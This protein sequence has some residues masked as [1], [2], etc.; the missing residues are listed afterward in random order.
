MRKVFFLALAA[1]V[2]ALLP[3]CTK[4]EEA[5][6]LELRMAEIW[7]K[8]YPTMQGNLAFAKYVEEKTNGAIKI[9][10]YDSGALG[11][12]NVTIEMTQSGAIDFVRVGTNPLTA[13]NPKMAA[14]SMP[15]LYR[16]REHM[17]KVLDGPI[18]D[19]MLESLQNQNLL[20]LCWYDPGF[21]CFY[22]SKKE[23]R[24]PA[25]TAGLKIRVQETPLMMDMVRA[26]GGSPTPMSLGEV[27]TA[28][29]N[30]VVDGA[31]NNW[32][33]YISGNHFEVA[34]FYTVDQ[35][36]A[37]P[38]MILV[39][40]ST[41]NKFTDAEKKIVKEGALE[42]ARV[43]RAAWLAFEKDSEAKARSAGCTITDLT[44]EERQL[45]VDA[46]MPLYDQPAYASYSDIIARIRAVQ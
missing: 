29:Q 36:M 44:P 30:N 1:L 37:S 7:H 27:Y 43:E 34:K 23:I 41:W 32:P 22:N 4:K 26:L 11:Q 28:I 10:V 6:K 14:L 5:R 46:L 18:G 19:E 24:T 17:F 13:L 38:E 31:E 21:R 16:D 8:E 20:G 40:T 12:E 45:F 33:S 3:G 15:F 25:D 42:G 35:H 2:L 39:S 9:E